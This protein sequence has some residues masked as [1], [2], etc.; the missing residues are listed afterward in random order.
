MER[1]WE[2]VKNGIKDGVHVSKDAVE[3]YS[4]IGKL[5]VEQ[6]GLRRKIDECYKSL[7]M[8]LRDM[9]VDENGAAVTE[10][11]SVK[12]YIADIDESETL[13]KE[14]DQQIDDLKHMNKA[15]C[16]SNEPIS[17]VEDTAEPEPVVSEEE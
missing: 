12:K 3:L 13:I 1:F 17:P 6:F 11:P 4:K 15:N 5:K 9:V 8:R 16:C 10:D 7:G 14:L 2:K